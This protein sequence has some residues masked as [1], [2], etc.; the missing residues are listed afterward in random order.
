MKQG[1]KRE[2]SS[3]GGGGG[4]VTWEIPGTLEPEKKSVLEESFRAFEQKR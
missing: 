4:S 3:L 1:R 2:T